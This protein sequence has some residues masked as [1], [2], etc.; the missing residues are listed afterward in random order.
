MDLEERKEMVL[1]GAG[2]VGV[3]ALTLK[4]LQPKIFPDPLENWEVKAHW[5]PA[6]EKRYRDSNY[7]L[8]IRMDPI[9]E[10]LNME[11][12][13]SSMTHLD[14]DRDY[15][16]LDKRDLRDTGKMDL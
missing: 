15:S 4:S 13:N 8:A 14:F 6:L 16:D 1:E 11:H 12:L 2:V 7:A 10:P 5:M 9:P 3:A